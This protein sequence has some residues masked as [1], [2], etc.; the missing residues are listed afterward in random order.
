MNSPTSRC[1]KKC[2]HKKR[3]CWVNHFTHKMKE[4]CFENI[5]LEQSCSCHSTPSLQEGWRGRFDK[6]FPSRPLKMKD[7]AIIQTPRDYSEVKD[8]FDAE[9]L[10]QKQRMVEK[11]Q[12]LKK[13]HPSIC[14]VYDDVNTHCTCDC[15]PTTWNAALEAVKKAVEGME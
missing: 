12:G 10:A 5:C 15:S 2:A 3:V 1:C 11:M 6:K 4:G 13:E 7:G 14:K 8:F 9:L